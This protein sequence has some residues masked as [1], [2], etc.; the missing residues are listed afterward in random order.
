MAWAGM[1]H[2]CSNSGPCISYSSSPAQQYSHSKGSRARDKAETHKCLVNPL[3]ILAK[4]NYMELR[5]KK[6]SWSSSWLDKMQSHTV[7]EMDTRPFKAIHA[8]YVHVCTHAHTYGI[9]HCFFCINGFLLSYILVSISYQET[10][11]NYDW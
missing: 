5:I 8:P 1:G 6:S 4:A 7:K 2:E 10:M 3:L 9:Y 11:E